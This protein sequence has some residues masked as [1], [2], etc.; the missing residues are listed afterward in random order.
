MPTERIIPAGGVAVNL[1]TQLSRAQ[2]PYAERLVRQTAELGLTPKQQSLIPQALDIIQNHLQHIPSDPEVPSILLH[3]A[4]ILARYDDLARVYLQ[5]DGNDQESLRQLQ[6][7]FQ[8]TS[9]NISSGTAFEGAPIR[10]RALLEDQH[11]VVSNALTI[12]V[13]RLWP[14]AKPGTLLAAINVATDQALTILDV[15]NETSVTEQVSRLSV[16]ETRAKVK[17]FLLDGSGIQISV[18]TN[19]LERNIFIEDQ[20]EFVRLVDQTEQNQRKLANQIAEMANILSA[21]RLG[22]S[23]DQI[24][25][26]YALL[27][28]RVLPVIRKAIYATILTTIARQQDA[29]HI[30]TLTPTA[31]IDP[32]FIPSLEEVEAVLDS[33]AITAFSSAQNESLQ[34]LAKRAI[35]YAYDVAVMFLKE[36]NNPNNAEDSSDGNGGPGRRGGGGFRPGGGTP[37][38]SGD[39]SGDLLQVG[40]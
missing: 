33:S 37:N 38:G 21:L 40:N 32:S 22:R 15:E 4:V 7:A 3:T 2:S 13:A 29:T 27:P 25:P 14:H 10:R 28:Q 26:V 6:H 9:F 31:I 8:L 36:R 23:L 12:F 1:G 24:D 30:E 18:L 20:Y 11:T 39:R 35:T 19:L 16:D 5:S 34:Y 17:K